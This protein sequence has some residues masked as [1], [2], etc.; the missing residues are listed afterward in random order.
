VVYEPHIS[1]EGKPYF[2]DRMRPETKLRFQVLTAA[3][4]KMAVFRVVAP[5][6]MVEVYR[7]FR[8]ACCLHH[9]TTRRTNPEDG[10]LRDRIVSSDS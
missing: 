9:Q 8:G 2:E 6:S 1:E 10:H 5:C 7:R 4:M 3:S